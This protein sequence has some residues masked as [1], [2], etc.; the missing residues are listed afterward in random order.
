MVCSSKDCRRMVSAVASGILP[1][2]LVLRVFDHGKG[3]YARRENVRSKL[4]PVSTQCI[5]M[6]WGRLKVR[7]A[8]RGGVA[9]HHIAGYVKQ[10]Q[11]RSNVS[12]CDLFVLTTVCAVPW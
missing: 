5:D 1:H 4:R 9:S 12:S 2:G 6:A 11:G 8:A 7:F 3:V 10:F